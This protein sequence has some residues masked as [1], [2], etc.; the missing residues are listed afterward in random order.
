MLGSP[1]SRANG[2]LL[3]QSSFYAGSA[4][5]PVM[6][7]TQAKALGPLDHRVSAYQLQIQPI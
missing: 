6:L 2:Y 1:L 5:L 3:S 4:I 7:I